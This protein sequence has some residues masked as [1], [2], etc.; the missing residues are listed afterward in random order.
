MKNKV[1]IEQDEEDIIETS[2]LA[3]AIIKIDEAVQ[4]IAASGLTEEAIVVLVFNS[5]TGVGK[6]TVRLVLRALKDLR[7]DYCTR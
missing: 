3:T 6:G 2:I 5:L 1:V 4:K 7:K